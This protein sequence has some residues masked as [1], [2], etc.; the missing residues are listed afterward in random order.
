MRHLAK[1]QD[2][3][4]KFYEIRKKECLFSLPPDFPLEVPLESPPDFHA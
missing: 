3:E 2:S 1:N 4:I